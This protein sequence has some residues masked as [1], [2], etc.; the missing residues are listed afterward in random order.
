MAGVCPPPPDTRRSYF[1]L[2][3]APSW[4][5]PPLPHTPPDLTTALSVNPHFSPPASLSSSAALSSRWR[6]GRHAGRKTGKGWFCGETS[7]ASLSLPL[8][9]SPAPS[10]SLSLALNQSP[11]PPLSSLLSLLFTQ[12]ERSTHVTFNTSLIGV[13]CPDKE[14]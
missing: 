14:S 9:I 4:Q 7:P 3:P 2:T 13:H 12:R 8:S 1:V 11:H 5:G 10:L 6:D